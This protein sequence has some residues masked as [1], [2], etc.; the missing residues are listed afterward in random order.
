MA[1]KGGEKTMNENQIKAILAYAHIS[2][3]TAA[4]S[5]GYTRQNLSVKIKRGTLTEAELIKLA[6]L[7]QAEYIPAK[8]RFRDGTQI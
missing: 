1:I 5:L 8:M 2:I 4:D 6:E 3:A 7:V